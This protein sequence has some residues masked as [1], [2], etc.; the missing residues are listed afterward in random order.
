[1][2]ERFANIQR[3]STGFVSNLP[4]APLPTGGKQAI[5]QGKSP[6]AVLQP[7]PENRWGVWALLPLQIHSDSQD[8]I[9]TDFGLRA[10]YTWHVGSVLLIPSLT[11]AWEHEYE[12]SSLPIT[13]S[14]AEFP[15]QNATFSGPHEGRNSAIV[16]VTLKEQWTPRFSRT[17]GGLQWRY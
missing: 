6:P 7:T 12:Y 2:D 1:L 15:G 9:R 8:S 3:G 10:S 17:G 11:A 14:S 16:N 4:V 5:E 13:V